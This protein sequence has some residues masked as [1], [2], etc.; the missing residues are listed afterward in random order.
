MKPEELLFELDKISKEYK[1]KP[2]DIH[3]KNNVIEDRI[4]LIQ[5]AKKEWEEKA[6][7]KGFKDACNATKEY[8]NEKL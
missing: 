8:L 7:I 3:A 4:E 5:Q 2:F 6:Y 1:G